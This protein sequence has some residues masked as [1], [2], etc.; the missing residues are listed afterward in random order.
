MKRGSSLR[1]IEC[2]IPPT[3]GEV[4]SA[5]MSLLAGAWRSEEHT[6]ELQS[7]AYLVCRLL[8]EKKK[9]V[10]FP[11][12]RRED[13]GTRQSPR[14]IPPRCRGIYRRTRLRALPV[15]TDTRQPPVPPR[16][17]PPRAR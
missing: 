15:P 11:P 17:R 16:T 13:Q 1:L 8:L 2:P 4:L 6:S 7:L 10:G 9:S 3:S 14:A 12:V 5:I